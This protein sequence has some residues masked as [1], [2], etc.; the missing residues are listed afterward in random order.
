MLSGEPEA[1]AFVQSRCDGAGM[2][3]LEILVERL[4]A[5]NQAQNLVARSTLASIWRRHIADS[6]QLLDHVS[7][8]TG[9][10]LDLGSGAGFPGLVIAIMRPFQ[11]IVLVESRRLRIQWLERLADELSLRNC[12]VEGRDI[13]KVASFEADVISARAFA[14][15]TR[16]IQL[17]A[18]FSTNSTEW[19]LPKGQSAG[20]DIEQLPNL[21]RSRFH[22]KQ[23]QTDP[24]AKIVVARGEMRWTK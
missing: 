10:W 9:T 3:R 21:L 17:S 20:Q 15:L 11:E 18:R 2:T 1:R 16:L 6:A 8:E 14:P 22:V 7:R 23:S 24:D 5:E 12:R 19:V 4:C 13:A